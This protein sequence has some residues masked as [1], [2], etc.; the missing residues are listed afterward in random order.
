M[1]WIIKRSFISS[2]SRASRCETRSCRLGR[3]Y[4]PFLCA[5]KNVPKIIGR[6]AAAPGRGRANVRVI[7]RSAGLIGAALDPSDWLSK[8]VASQDR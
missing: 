7:D 2:G 8:S 5:A 1:N 6:L 4:V 3:F